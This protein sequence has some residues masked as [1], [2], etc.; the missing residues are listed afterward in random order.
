MSAISRSSAR[1]LGVIVTEIAK[2][3]DAA[4]ELRGGYRRQAGGQNQ[5][6]RWRPFEATFAH[7][8]GKCHFTELY[9]VF[10]L[11]HRFD[12]VR[13]ARTVDIRAVR[14]VEVDDR[15]RLPIGCEAYLGMFATDGAIVED[16]FQRSQPPGAKERFR[17]PNFAFDRRT[18]AAQ[19]DAPSHVD[20]SPG[21]KDF[22]ES[23]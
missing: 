5:L 4:I 2:V 23:S 10:L 7:L 15:P 9:D 8:D 12:I 21:F 17:V 6:V 16:D 11:Q 22:A 19:T 1:K 13:D 20:P 3:G 14:A 18:D